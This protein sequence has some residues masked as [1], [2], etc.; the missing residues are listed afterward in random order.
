MPSVVLRRVSASITAAA[1]AAGVLVAFAGP[2]SAG[3]VC[4]KRNGETIACVTP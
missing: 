1:L 4:V 2:A 3:E